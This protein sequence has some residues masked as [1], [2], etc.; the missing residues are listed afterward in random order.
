MKR[1]EIQGVVVESLE[2]YRDGRGW[3]AEL[4]RSDEGVVPAMGYASVTFPGHVRGPHEHVEQTDV[5]MFPGIGRFKLRL[6]DSRED[7]ETKGNI[8]TLYVGDGN[9]VKVVVPPGVVHGYENVSTEDGLVFNHPDRLYAGEGKAEPVDE[10]RH[11]DDD[12]CSYSME[13]P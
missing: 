5:F 8:M 9:P 1:G 11:E 12:D 2:K 6:W 3:L 7:S 13:G 10:L 4:W